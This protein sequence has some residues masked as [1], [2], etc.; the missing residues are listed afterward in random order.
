MN[1]DVYAGS[2]LDSHSLDAQL[3]SLHPAV[4]YEALEVLSHAVLVPTRLNAA[5]RCEEQL[6]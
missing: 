4:I 3:H 6:R 5:R 2:R 1:G